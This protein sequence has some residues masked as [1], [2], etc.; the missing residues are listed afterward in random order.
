MKKRNEKGEK[1][2]RVVWPPKLDDKGRQGLPELTTEIEK[3]RAKK[4][5]DRI[6]TGGK[7][8]E[9]YGDGS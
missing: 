3:K 1:T 5:K 2:G 7:R 4:N 8:R 9:K 6:S